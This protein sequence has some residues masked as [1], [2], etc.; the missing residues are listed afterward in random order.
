MVQADRTSGS[1]RIAVL[2]GGIAG[3][4]A[5]FW[6]TEL[7]P[8]ADISILEA[9]DRVGGLIGTR[10]EDGNLLE[11]GPL[12]FPTGAPAT[13]ELLRM[14]GLGSLCVPSLQAGSIGLWDGKR[15][16]PF[17]RS[18]LAFLRSRLLSP[19]GFL[20]LLAEPFMPRSQDQEDETVLEFF[21]RRTGEEFLECFMEPFAAGILSGDPATMSMS[22]NLPAFHTMEKTSGSLA[23]GFW[24][25]AF[26]MRKAMQKNT[27]PS[28][29]MVTSNLGSQGLING[30]AEELRRRKV[31][32]LLSH[33][34][35]SIVKDGEYRIG[36]K[37]KDGTLQAQFDIVIS[38]LP[39]YALAPLI[40][41]W[42]QDIREFLA[43]IP[44]AS[45]VLAHL[46]LRKTDL[47]GRFAGEGFL[48]QCGAGEGI[49]SVFFSSRML[50]NR[51]PRDSELLRVMLGGARRPEIAM[52]A[53]G[54]IH[55][56]ATLAIRKILNPSDEP[57]PFPC[58]R[59]ER[60]LPQLLLGHT[61]GVAKIRH[62]L[63]ESLPGFYLAGTS[64]NG[65]G[66]ENG[67]ASGKR[68][69]M[70]ALQFYQSSLVQ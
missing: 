39:S 53:G 59:H 65:A 70:E 54:A 21:R 68:A 69:A 10:N 26:S 57:K 45:L 48:L 31:R 61:K 62:W 56:L 33:H 35:T 64:F 4:S 32:L 17:P 3:L 29:G 36:L 47:E 20:R 46:G 66:I 27:P 13:G 15:L 28:S 22:A 67:V 42:P 24:K 6:L 25:N 16:L 8:T 44:H 9:Q 52:L 5:A 30:L 49:L 2:G 7:L 14:A 37:T 55:R 11:T 63:Q 58:I 38:C 50:P 60:G 23:I 41:E 1:P 40:P 43:A 18:P 34:I 19:L 12:A 51:C